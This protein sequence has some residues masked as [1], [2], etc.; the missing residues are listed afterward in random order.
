[1]KP[2]D[3]SAVIVTGAAIGIGFALATRLAERGAK[4]MIADREGAQAAADK[5]RQ[6]GHTAAALSLIHI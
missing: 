6:L 2:L 5:L 1:M 3:Q 4:V